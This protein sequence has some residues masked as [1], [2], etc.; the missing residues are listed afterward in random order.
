MAEI[1]QVGV[2]GAGPHGPWHRTGQRAG[3]LRRRPARGRRERLAEGHGQDREAARASGREGQGSS[4]DA[5]AVR[6]ADPADL[7]YGDLAGSDLVVEAI[8]ESLGAQA[9]DVA[10]GRRHRQARGGTSPP[11][12][13]RWPSIDQAAA[14]SRPERFLGL[15]YFNPAQ[16]M[17]LVEVDPRGDDVRRGLRGRPRRSPARRAS[18]PIPTRD[19]AGFIVNR[20][21]VPYMLDAI[22]ALRGGR[23]LGRRD[24]RGD[25]GRRRAPDGPADA[26]RLRRARHPRRRS[27]TCCSTSSASG[28]SRSRRLLRKMLAAGWYGR[29]SRHGLLR[30]RGRRAGAEP[31]DLSDPRHCSTSC[32][33]RRTAAPLIATGAV[34]VTVGVAL[35]ELRLDDELPTASSSLIARA[36]RRRDLRAR[37]AGAPG[38]PPV[39]VPVRAARVRAA[40]A[41]S[42]AADARRRARR[43]LRRLPGRARSCGRRCCSRAP[44]CGRRRRATRRSAR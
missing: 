16:V 24:R 17:K 25:E 42:R 29:K 41:V 1:K 3:R 30:L 5:D 40:A 14:T 8:T 28:A 26:R 38:G 31:R 20:L 34:L 13:R 7:D 35:E 37:G 43:R 2:L 10:R 36:R 4:R 12:R 22:R 44:R 15:H 33:R 39:R 32:G 21:L 23:R 6:G 27:A 18:W 11:T 9:R 19:T